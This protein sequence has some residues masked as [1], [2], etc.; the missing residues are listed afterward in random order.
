MKKLL[1]L[2]FLVLIYACGGKESESAEQK[3][4]LESLTF[5]VDTVV[6]DPGDDFLALSFGLGA[7]DLS[8]DQKELLFF[9]N[10]PLSLVTVSL[11]EL[12]VISKTEFETEG[13]N[14]VGSFIGDL[15]AGPSNHVFI[16]GFN[17]QGIFTSEG[18]MTENLKIFPEGLDPEYTN[19]F[20]KIYGNS[21][22]DFQSEKFYAQPYGE[23]IKDNELW[24]IDPASKSYASYP[25]PKMKSVGDLAIT[26]TQKTADGTMSSYYGPSAYMEIQNNQVLISGGTMSGLYKLSSQ[27]DSVEFIDIQHNTVPNEWNITVQKESSDEASFKE[28]RR[29]ISEQLN[30][31]DFKWDETREMYIRFG[32]RT[33]LGENRGDPS[34][35]ELYLFAYDKDFNVL[36]ET[37]IAGLETIPSSY[38]W[39][40]GKLYS[41]VNVEDELGFAVFT[42]DF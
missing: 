13:P 19:D 15:E 23:I 39:R 28:D 6:V 25:L 12:K 5:S 37:K 14:S 10:K 11:D 24:V 7:F 17:G 1:T 3:N 4:I 21:M 41:Y 34:S 35:Y 31:M 16:K 33:F 40:D 9:Q 22:Y 20:M 30:F 29:K 38:F 8:P 36:G 42:F 2:S 27:A 18:E 26:F 32:K